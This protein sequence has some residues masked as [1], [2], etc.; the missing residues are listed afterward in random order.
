[1]SPVTTTAVLSTEVLTKVEKDLLDVEELQR[2]WNGPADT[3]QQE[4][5]KVNQAQLT[6]SRSSASD[7]QDRQVFLYVDGELWGR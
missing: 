1:M 5:S 6:V 4:V 7:F 3:A 2:A